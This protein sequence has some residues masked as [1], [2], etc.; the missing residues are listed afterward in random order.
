MVAPTM[1]KKA[2]KAV[3]ALPATSSDSDMDNNHEVVDI[4]RAVDR[5]RTNSRQLPTCKVVV[6]EHALPI[7]LMGA[8]MYHSLLEPL[9]L[10]SR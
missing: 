8:E 4:V 3:A 9:P 2:V 10:K 7:N 6:H 5:R 1:P